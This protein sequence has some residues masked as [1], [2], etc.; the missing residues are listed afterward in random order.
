VVQAVLKLVQARPWWLLFLWWFKVDQAELYIYLVGAYLKLM[1]HPYNSIIPMVQSHS[2][3][4]L[5]RVVW[6]ICS[7]CGSVEPTFNIIIPAQI[8]MNHAELSLFSNFQAW[9]VPFNISH[10][11]CFMKNFSRQSDQ[12]RFMNFN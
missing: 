7:M 1:K 11:L 6:I 9:P 3:F 10:A 4:C 12:Q 5:F 2:C 8:L